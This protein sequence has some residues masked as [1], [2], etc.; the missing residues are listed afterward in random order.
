MQRLEIPLTVTWNFAKLGKKLT[1]FARLG[2]GPVINIRSTASTTS[3]GTDDNNRIITSG[4]DL[5][6]T[7]SRIFMALFVQ[8]GAGIKFK[9]PGGF[10]SLEARSNFGM[11][12]QVLRKM[13]ASTMELAHRYSYLDQ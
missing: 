5:D 10:I 12:N 3:T 13:D 4:A 1:T 11:S 2:G 9:T 6:R 8:A 7:E